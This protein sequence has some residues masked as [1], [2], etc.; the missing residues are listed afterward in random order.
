MVILAAVFMLGLGLVALS[1]RAHQSQRR[2][3]R[4]E[5]AATERLWSSYV[6]QARAERLTAEAGHRAAA[7]TA[8][9]N[10]AA[11]RPST[12]L[13][14]E[15]L[16]SFALRDLVR[17]VSWPLQSGAY[18]F[19]FDPTLEHYV[20]RYALDE[21]S[22]F[23]LADNSPVR[24]FRA[25]DAGLATNAVVKEF[26]FSL[27][28]RFIAAQYT[29]GEIV[30]WERDTGRAAHLFSRSDGNDRLAWRP[31]FTAD[32]QTFCARSISHSNH[33]VFIDLNSGARR[34]TE[35]L[36]VNDTVRLNPKGNLL[37]WYRGNDLFL[38]DAQTGAQQKT[39]PWPAEVMS[40]RWDWRSERISVWCRDGTLNVI[41]V[42][43]G[44][45]RQMGGRYVGPWVQQFS[46]DGSML[47]TAGHDGTS[48]LWD[49]TE[50]RLFAQTR[51]AR[52]FTFGRDGERI[53]FAIPG[54]LVGV[55]RITKPAGY[56]LLQ[57]VV[58]DTATV[59]FQDVSRDGR[60][61][62][63]TPPQW[64]NRPGFELFDLVSNRPAL[65][66]PTNRTVRVGFHPLEPKVIVASRDGLRT[67]QITNAPDGQLRLDPAQTI[68][69]PKG[70]Q[71]HTFSFSG[72]GNHIALISRSGK[73]VVHPLDQPD[74][75]VELEGSLPTPELSG[76]ASLTGA[77]G[78]AVSLDGKWV[79][80]GADTL[81]RIPTIWD[82]QTGK[83]TRHLDSEPGNVTLSPDGRWL[84][85]VGTGFC[86]VWDTTTWQQ[87]WQRSRAAMLTTF[88]AAA[89]A[90]DGS[91]M[92][93]SP[94]VDEIEL[95]EP[96]T[97]E[98]I[99]SLSGPNIVAITGLRLAADGRLLAAPSSDGRIHVWDLAALR[100]NL[101]RF[102]L[103]WK[104][105]RAT[106]T[107]A[108][109]EV[110][111]TWRATP[112]L[113]AGIGLGTVSL[114]GLLGMIVLQRHGRL[115]RDFV[116]TTELAAQQAR[117][118]AVERELNELKSRFVSMV[119]HEFRTPLGITMSAIE[120]LRNHLELLDE[121][122]RQELFDD[123]FSSTRR[124][125]A[126][127][128]QVLVLGRVE[129]GR[130]A[131]RAVPVDLDAL[132]HRLAEESV[133][134]G[135]RRC[136]IEVKSQ[137]A[138]AGAQADESLLR[139]IF[140]N[141]LSNAVKYSAAG[142]TVE[143][144]IGRDG[145]NAVFTVR[146]RGI[147]IAE[148]DMPRLFQ[149]FHRA[150]NVGDIPGTGLGLV[151]VKRCVELYSGAIEVHSRQNEGTTFTVKLPLFA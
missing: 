50:A 66:I 122:K 136:S 124:M 99:A 90:A 106:P 120:L 43:S 35:V 133:S 148:A 62:V 70:F 83:V 48:R 40:C 79:V 2:A 17:E 36:G 4:A 101:A 149:A 91:F 137:G 15:A 121:A 8:I 80:A 103:D 100:G 63:W 112:T 77:G 26:N 117:E 45:I 78:L 39:I 105:G 6:A 102:G 144:G 53:A 67:F 107:P 146:D 24:V 82:A 130:L 87:K 150:T 140:S 58:G 92:A 75:F 142:Q 56:R 96:D 139:H 10:A 134:A 57:G 127:M 44:R 86:T 28:G 29:T 21:L 69:V 20:V 22:M 14:D 5:A 37:F 3:E 76:P 60:W 30:L 54:Q 13:R 1:F 111:P 141:L 11:I 71:A 138:L 104:S 115:T 81:E 25:A 114:A 118:L 147:G 51:E 38:H 123:I 47:A 9:S 109:D 65:F 42:Q 143:F 52:A 151:I 31:T 7:L 85:V 74:Y 88:G 119:S 89:F 128:E 34:E 72:S 93:F 16:A 32:D 95:A 18:G 116:H 110:E 145:V 125:A 23:R 49:V 113:F 27:T 61:A 73:V 126:L 59:W 97:G 84:V 132:C 68:P 94:S 131:V 108:G 135:N 41:D 129:A 12:Q 46:P 33:V 64:M 19:Y 98:H 55:W